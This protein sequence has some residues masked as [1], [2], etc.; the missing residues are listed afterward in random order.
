MEETVKTLEV[1]TQPLSTI[2]KKLEEKFAE[3][4][5]QQSELMD[6]LGKQLLTLELAIPGVYATVL[7]L[8]AGEKATLTIDWGFGVTFL[9]WFVALLLTLLAIFPKA[10]RVDSS[11]L[12]EIENFFHKSAKRKATLLSWSVFLF[13]IGIGCSVWI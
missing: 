6:T 7:K 1:T 13:F 10:Y 8:V 3:S 5:T 2:D 12:D 9:L 4:I 11:R